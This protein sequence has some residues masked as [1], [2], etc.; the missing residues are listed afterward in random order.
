MASYTLTINGTDRTTCIGNRSITIDNET[1]SSASTMNF[2]MVIR[3]SG[4]IP[5]GDQEVIVTQDGTRLFGG[6]ILRTRPIKKGSLVIWDIEC[7]DYTRDLDRNLVVEGYQDMTDSAIIKDIVDNYCGGTGITYDNVTEGVSISTIVF[8]YMPPSECFSV[9]CKLTGRQWYIDYDKD[10]YYG[11]KTTSEAPFHIPSDKYSNLVLGLDNSAIR[12]RVYV[13]GG[14]Y[15]SDEVTIKQVADGEQTV[16]YLPEKPH[17]MSILEGATPKTVG[18]KNVNDFTE[19]DYLMSYQEKYVE[20][21][22]APAA[23]T[24]MTFSYKYNIPV[25]VAVEDKDSIE[26]YGQLEYIIF[27]K[28]IDTIAQARERA[29]AELTDYAESIVSGRFET[30]E[31]G[32]RPGQYIDID[33]SDLGIDDRFV[34]QSVAAKSH[35]GGKFEYVIRIVSAEMLGIVQFLVDLLE[36][37]KSQLNISTDEVVDEI[38]TITGESFTLVDGTPVLTSHEGAY[39][40]DSDAD[41]DVA[42]WDEV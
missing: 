25:L 40:Y 11:L 12:N 31:T 1:G 42:E 16:F 38:T 5:E 6:R 27:D 29:V 18:I 15:L 21:E 33:D 30:L 22:T 4:A 20:T 9:I 41:W 36:S 7:V 10:I 37:N 26:K 35:G 2:S 32:F 39:K 28:T 14:T 24:V 19:F 23:D 3:D 34:V 17:E 13:R 8:S